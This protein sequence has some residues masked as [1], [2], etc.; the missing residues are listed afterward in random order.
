MLLILQNLTE[1]DC[2]AVVA[3]VLIALSYILAIVNYEAGY[4]LEL[5][6][7]NVCICILVSNCLATVPIAG[8]QREIDRQ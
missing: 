1:E 3:F 5:G 7:D 8:K 6:E 2:T 4:P